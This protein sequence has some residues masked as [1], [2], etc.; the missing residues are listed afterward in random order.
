MELIDLTFKNNVFDSLI[1][2]FY[3]SLIKELK[4]TNFCF[5][6][7]IVISNSKEYSTLISIFQN[8]QLYPY[9]ANVSFDGL[10][11]KDNY[12]EMHLLKGFFSKITIKNSIIREDKEFSII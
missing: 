12:I 2:F 7:N 5:E 6:N 1:S 8:K 11:I 9:Y 4:V 3:H 10:Y